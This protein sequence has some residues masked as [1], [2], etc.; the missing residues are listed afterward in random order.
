MADGYRL[1]AI[2]YRL[3]AQER[4]V[5][6]QPETVRCGG[7]RPAGRCRDASR[8][9]R[10][11]LPHVSG[12]VN[13]ASEYLDRGVILTNQPMIEPGLTIALPLGGGTATIGVWAAVQPSTYTSTQY[14]SMAPGERVP[15]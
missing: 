3:L 2:S 7:L 9:G 13:V 12:K 14:F 5:L 6:Y 4:L 1:S 11:D 8:R 15:I 10:A